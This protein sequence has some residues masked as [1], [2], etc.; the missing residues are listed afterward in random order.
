MNTHNKQF[1]DEIENFRNIFFFFLSFQ[2]NF[3]GTQKQV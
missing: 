1:I 3:V 2:K